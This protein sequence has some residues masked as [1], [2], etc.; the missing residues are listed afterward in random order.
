MTTE[1][2]KVFLPGAQTPESFARFNKAVELRNRIDFEC[3]SLLCDMANEGMATASFFMG[4]LKCDPHMDL[5]EAQEFSDHYAEQI[6]TLIQR[7][8]DADKEWS[9]ALVGKR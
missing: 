4:G 6:T 5:E 3:Y 8:R 1:T 7:R 2:T 9:H